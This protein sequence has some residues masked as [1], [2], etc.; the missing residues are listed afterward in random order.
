MKKIYF[1]RWSEDHEAK[2]TID[3]TGN[4]EENEELA[5]EIALQTNSQISMIGFREG[6]LDI[7]E[8]D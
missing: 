6:S 8:C 1:V 2:V 5:E 7:Q 4:K 3:D